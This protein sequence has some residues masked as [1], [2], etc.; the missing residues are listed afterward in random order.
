[1]C[2]F[3]MLHIAIIYHLTHH[4][5]NTFNGM[6]VYFN[7][8]MN[9]FINIQRYGILHLSQTIF[10]VSEF[11][12]MAE[13][14][15]FMHQHVGLWISVCFIYWKYPQNSKQKPK[16]QLKIHTTKK[17]CQLKIIVIIYSKC[18]EMHDTNP[19]A[20]LSVK[21]NSSTRFRIRMLWNR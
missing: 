17:T 18:N 16:C 19:K 20:F 2:I 7:N 3:K 4:D 1:M 13:W 6:W 21:R 15:Q 9:E 5:V 8:M 12:S 11:Q 10:I 14:L